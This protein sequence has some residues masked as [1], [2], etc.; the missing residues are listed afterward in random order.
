MKSLIRNSFIIS[1]LSL[2]VLVSNTSFASDLDKEKRWADQIIDS[3]LD[4]DAIY[5]NDGKSNFLAIET[6]ADNPKDT[7]IIIIHG[8]G[9][10]PDW[11]TVIQPLRVQL[12][13]NGWNTLSLQMPILGNDATGKDYEPLMK[14]VPPRIDA[15]IRQLAKT[16]AKK[17]IIVAHSLG[18]RMTNFYL[19]RKKVYQD[20]Q[21]QTPIVAYVSIG[22]NTS[23]SNDF[24][25]IK[26]P[27]FDLLGSDDLP[28]VLAS[29]PKRAKTSKDNKN[30]RQRIIAGASH[31]FEDKD[32]EL[33][34]A[35]SDAINSFDSSK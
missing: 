8:I 21:S 14:E 27:V 18:A 16:G 6:L 9:I 1:L 17:V 13:A 25:K 5:L 7:G 31:F 4:G 26:I 33:V 22:M 20:A 29:A 30:Y 23:N 2:I 32:D 15:G 19:A 35:V 3:L 34:K 12:A 11:E 28:G 10:H 24:E